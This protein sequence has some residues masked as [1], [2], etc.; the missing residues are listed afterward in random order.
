MKKNNEESVKMSPQQLEEQIRLAA[1]YR[2]I[3]RGCPAGEGVE[4]WLEAEA[5]LTSQSEELEGG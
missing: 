4:D 1:Y 5:G 2:W 3:E